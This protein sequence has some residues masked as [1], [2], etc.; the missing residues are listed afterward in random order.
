MWSINIQPATHQC[1]ATSSEMHQHHMWSTKTR[2]HV[3]GPRRHFVVTLF[4]LLSP[5]SLFGAQQSEVYFA[6]VTDN[7]ENVVCAC[8]NVNHSLFSVAPCLHQLSHVLFG[9]TAATVEQ[10]CP[11]LVLCVLSGEKSRDKS[12]P[13][14]EWGDA[15]RTHSTRLSH[16]S[17]PYPSFS[18]S[19]RFSHS[20]NESRAG[21]GGRKEQNASQWRSNFILMISPLLLLLPL[22][23]VYKCGI[24]CKGFSLTL[25]I[26]TNSTWTKISWIWIPSMKQTSNSP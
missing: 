3:T 12:S 11:C 25:Q 8:R 18:H 24:W 15:R 16:L 21:G 4:L 20:L 9:C 2:P 17:A 19:W 5:P 22:L 23:L 7:W 6:K 14:V 1:R 26:K 13:P 10:G